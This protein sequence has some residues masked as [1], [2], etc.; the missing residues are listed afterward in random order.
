V[1]FP[2]YRLIGY[3]G[4]PGSAAFGRLGVGDLDARVREIERLGAA[5]AH[6]RQ[7][8]PVLELIAVVAQSHPGSDGRY[9]VRVPPDV[10]QTYLD[11]ARRH[12]ALLLLN[13]QPGRAHFMDEVEALEPWLRHPEVGLA[14][15]PEWA[16]RSGQ[17]P[18]DVFGRTTGAEIDAVAAAVSRLVGS[19]DLPQKALVVHQLAPSVVRGITAVRS[20]PGVSVIKS[21]DGIGPPAAKEST[22]RTLVAG[23]PAAVRPGFKLF[24]SEDLAGHGRLMT[25]SEVLALRP[26][27]D[28]VLYE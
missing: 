16:V 15:D 12:R 10:V 17:V 25:P 21:V 18:G 26:T 19:L 22:W 23:L 24:F 3:S 7:P 9:R 27:P 1:L 11:A 8:L 4:G 13:I 5:Y 2:T 28:Y 6:G 14:L 20:R